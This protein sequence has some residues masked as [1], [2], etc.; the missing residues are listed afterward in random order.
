MSET[1]ETKGRMTLPVEQGIE[2][3]LRSMIQKWGADAVRNS[4]G[5]E[6]PEE[7]KDLG[8]EVYSTLCMVRADQKYAKANMDKAQQKYLCSAFVTAE[9]KMVKIDILKEYYK[10]Q[11][12]ID[13]KHNPKKWWEV[14]DRTA[15]KKVAPKN[16]DFNPKTGVVTVKDCKP[17]H[18][19][20]VSFLVYQIW[21]STSM[22]NA[23]TNDWAGEHP[24]SVDPYQPEVF[25]HLLKF[26]DEWL[27]RNPKTDM[28]RFTSVAYHFT[29]IY[30][31]DAN[32]KYRDW[33][34]YTDCISPLAIEDFK[35]AK[36]YAL[37]PEDFIQGGLFNDVNAVPAPQYLDWIDFIN[38]FVVKLC[39]AWND[40][41]HKAGRKSMMFFCDH[42]I[43]TEPYGE[44]YAK[45]G[46]DGIVNACKNGLEARRIADVPVDIVKEVRLYPYFFPVNLKNE[47]S[48]APGGNPKQECVDFWV[49]VRR[50]LA[51]NLV[52]RIGFG[53]YPS[54]AIKYPDFIDYV[55]QL[56]E[57]FRTMHAHTKQSKPY[58]STV[59]VAV[60]NCWGKLRSWICKEWEGGGLMET[61]TGLPLEVQFIN[62]SDIEKHGIP[63]GVQVLINTGNE[64]TAWSGG[65]HWLNP[66]IVAAVR[67]F[68]HNGGGLIGIGE[69]TAIQNQGRFFQLADV[70]GVDKERNL[71]RGK[72]KPE[73]T[74]QESHFIMEDQDGA[75]NLGKCADQ[76]YA[77]TAQT[78]AL[79]KNG[80]DLIIAANECGKGR[81]VYLAGYKHN[82][83]NT[84][85]IHRAI[86]WTANKESELK[87]WFCSN[88]LTECAAYPET[89]KV[90][91]FN[92]TGKPQS[93]TVHS[94]KGG[95]VEVSLDAYASQWREMTDFE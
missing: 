70:L 83:A 85:M 77:Y 86:F 90:F 46:F 35:K 63:E 45:A 9:S 47:P 37:R 61:L 64:G 69:P 17:Y 21:D 28:V 39:R 1:V 74:S 60:V 71:S 94:D 76:V 84:R 52:D 16:W 22:Y 73:T 38:A 58:Q 57:E 19:Y 18:Q 72:S 75:P 92:N 91:I 65:A 30:G 14:I 44:R 8:L 42:W 32:P 82:W 41:V 87:K 11:F 27:E 55:A 33:S 93:T 34:G 24:T 48:F 78:Q 79:V 7:L 5:T 66:K 81:A 80:G 40:R 31:H 59:K 89:G 36:G 56:S 95:T 10:E 54:L 20:S 43:G 68:V 62:F 53:G 51:R 26:L 13:T 67:E 25:E 2:E 88:P 29:N 50:A 49:D 3:E 15:D 23:L 6:L 4:D 12:A